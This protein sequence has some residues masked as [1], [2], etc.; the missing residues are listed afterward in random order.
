M[1]SQAMT[2]LIL[3]DGVCGLC[4]RSVQFLLARAAPTAFVYA[5]LQSRLATERLA[6]HGRD[7]G[8]LDTMCVLTHFGTPS[9]RLLVKGRAAIYVLQRLGGAWRL[10]SL[11]SLLPT[12]LLDVVY[13]FVARRRYRW[14]GRDEQCLLMT[15]EHRAKFI[16]EI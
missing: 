8:D 9:E 11:L 12:A 7:A 13:S 3:Y 1:L 2:D 5:P 10:V 4:Q 6:R 14:F 16:A 15:A